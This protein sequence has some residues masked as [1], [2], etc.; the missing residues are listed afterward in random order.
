MLYSNSATNNNKISCGTL[1]F[2]V[3]Q[4]WILKEET[5]MCKQTVNAQYNLLNI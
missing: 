5:P 2:Q 3:F 4:R 1:K